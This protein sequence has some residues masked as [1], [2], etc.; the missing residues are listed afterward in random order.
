MSVEAALDSLRG[1]RPV[2]TV[3]SNGEGAVVL[4]A[5]EVQ[6]H[7]VAWTIRHTSGLLCAP[8]PAAR[9]DEL[10]LPPMV[11]RNQ[12]LSD[13]RYTVSVD[14]RSGVTTGISAV[15]R[16]LTFR[17]LSAPDTTP[18]DLIRPGHVLPVCT[19]PGGVT[20]RLA[21]EEAAVDLCTQAGLPPVAVLATLVSDRGDVLPLPGIR[22]LA[23]RH[24]LPVLDINELV[25]HTVPA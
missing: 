22:E 9:A 23:A 21:A 6:P 2:L 1:G 8:M 24:G 5:H 4:A 25:A 14:A 18:G 7:W 15:D 16:A 17:M 19:R 3:A 20:E 13:I 11:P 12:E 10:G